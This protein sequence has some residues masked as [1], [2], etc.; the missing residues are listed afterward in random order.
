MV[1]YLTINHI[2]ELQRQ[3]NMVQWPFTEHFPGSESETE[4]RKTW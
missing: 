4:D 1:I 3:G 2:W